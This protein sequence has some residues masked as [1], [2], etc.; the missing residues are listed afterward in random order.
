MNELSVN[1][2][3]SVFKKSGLSYYRVAKILKEDAGN[4]VKTLKK[5]ERGE[6]V[7]TRTIEKYAK[8]LGMIG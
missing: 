8:A 6:S 5:M 3:V 4:V 7:T 1:D 2:V